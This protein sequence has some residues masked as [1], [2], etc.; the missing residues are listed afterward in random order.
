M[1]HNKRQHGRQT[2]AWTARFSASAAEWR[3][4]AND[5]SPLGV[6]LSCFGGETAPEVGAS[7]DLE[8]QPRGDDAPLRARVIVRWSERDA[9]TRQA[10]FGVSFA[11]PTAPIVEL[12]SASLRRSFFW[13]SPP[14]HA[15]G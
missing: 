6:S 9:I 1:G 14:Q 12:L 15:E 10:R 2:I 4:V 11:D 5:A 8:L 3:G 13:N 7:G